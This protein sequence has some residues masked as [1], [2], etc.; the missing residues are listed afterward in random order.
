MSLYPVLYTGMLGACG[1]CCCE[2]QADRPVCSSQDRA[3]IACTHRV[4]RVTGKLK[5]S[6]R[7]DA[8]LLRVTEDSVFQDSV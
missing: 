1:Y 3:F 2:G 5:I 8:S 6:H 7:I 4:P